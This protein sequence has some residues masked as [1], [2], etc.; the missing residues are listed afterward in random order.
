MLIE[1]KRSMYH[2]FGRRE[3]VNLLGFVIFASYRLL[4][5]LLVLFSLVGFE[6]S[7]SVIKLWVIVCVCSVHL[8][9]FQLS[10][11]FADML[12]VILLREN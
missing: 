2:K 3:S 5:S 8:R 9:V 12:M 10:N 1:L 11:S 7:M 4:S 6:L